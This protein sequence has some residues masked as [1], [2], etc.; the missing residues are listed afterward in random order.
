MV[1]RNF[2]IG[3]FSASLVFFCIERQAKAAEELLPIKQNNHLGY[4]DK[5]SKIVINPHFDK[6]G[7]FSDGVAP[8]H[9]GKKLGY[10]DKSGFVA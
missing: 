4:A 5:N 7:D 3:V 8:V 10:I 2:M 6:A 9:L 1:K